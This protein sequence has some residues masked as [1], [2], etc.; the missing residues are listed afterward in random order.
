MQREKNHRLQGW[1]T[2]QD[3]RAHDLAEQ[4]NE[5]IGAFTGQPGKATERTVFRWL[6]G[7]NRWPQARFRKALE[8]VTGLSLADLGFVP[9]SRREATTARE[10]QEDPMRRRHFFGVATGA[11]FALGAADP[12]SAARRPTVGLRDVEPLRAELMKLWRLD[13]QHGGS[14]TLEA[15]AASL[16]QRT[17]GLQRNGSAH[18]RIRCRLY[19]LA[20]AFTATAMWAAVDSRRMR[21]AQRYLDEAVKL[22]GLSGDGE[23]QHQTWRYAAMLATQRGDYAEAMAASEAAVNT[24][25]HRSDHLYKSISHS[26]L[27]LSAANAGERARARRALDRAVEAF[28]RAD[29]GAW[30]SAS[31]AYYTHAE[32]H[33]LTGIVHYRLGDPERAEYHVHQCLAELRPDQHRNRAYYTAQAALFQAA[34][35]DLEQAVETAARVIAPAD[36]TSGRIPHLLGTFTSALNMTAPDAR[37]TRDWNTRVRDAH[38]P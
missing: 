1:M 35:G 19:A 21:A 5:A 30:R 27:A 3:L 11:A 33:G 26:R 32:L 36:A 25:V 38:H 31:V 14:V 7:E 17:L 13:D 8:Q 4:V 9:T 2:E 22:A 37:V 12:V 23:V 15:K 29:P 18:Q 34:Q 24:Q 10:R 6:S 16:A 20:A 28:D